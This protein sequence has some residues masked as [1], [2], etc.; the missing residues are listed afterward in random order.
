M[1]K[2]RA[3]KWSLFNTDFAWSNMKSPDDSL[4]V[5]VHIFVSPVMLT[6][7]LTLQNNRLWRLI[8]LDIIRPH[9]M[10]HK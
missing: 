4:G 3:A 5:K 7:R 10:I 6:T 9:S 1:P 2:T 8:Q